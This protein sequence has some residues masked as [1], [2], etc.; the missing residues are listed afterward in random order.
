MIYNSVFKQIKRLAKKKSTSKIGTGG[1]QTNSEKKKRITNR[2][3]L[4]K[5]LKIQPH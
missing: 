3:D 5:H 1:L 2:T 4:Q